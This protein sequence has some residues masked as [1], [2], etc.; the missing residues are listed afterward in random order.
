MYANFSETGT[1]S[2]KLKAYS[3]WVKE[4]DL[5][6]LSNFSYEAQP[7]LSSVSCRYVKIS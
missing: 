7:L 4:T 2:E 6:I 5:V 3:E 1:S